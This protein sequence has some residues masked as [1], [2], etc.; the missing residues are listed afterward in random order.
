[1]DIKKLSKIQD[2]HSTRRVQKP[3]KDSF[4]DLNEVE[5]STEEVAK[6]VEKYVKPI[7][8]KALFDNG[9]AGKVEVTVDGDKVLIT[10]EVSDSALK[11]ALRKARLSDE[12]I[13]RVLNQRLKVSDDTVV[14]EAQLQSLK[15][16]IG[17]YGIEATVSIKDGDIIVEAVNGEFKEGEDIIVDSV[18]HAWQENNV[19][20]VEFIRDA[21]EDDTIEDPEEA[22]RIAAEQAGQGGVENEDEEDDAWKE[23]EDDESLST[24]DK[25]KEWAE[26]VITPVI[27]SHLD[28][29]GITSRVEVTADE[30]GVTIDLAATSKSDDKDLEDEEL[31]GIVD[32]L[33]NAVV[34]ANKGCYR[35]RLRVKDS[36][37]KVLRRVIYG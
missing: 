1:M 18:I 34:A 30:N 29:V 14:N 28:E 23:H 21:D 24:E 33:L 26:E 9:E 10:S 35:T 31:D 22:A 4:E 16:L 8:E 13:R 3:V 11:V 27:K 25:M 2:D 15:D 36:S 6:W 37:N 12:K 17:E 7:V 32:S 20:N 5:S 19:Q